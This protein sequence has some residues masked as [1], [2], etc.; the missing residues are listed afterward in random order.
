MTNSGGS[1]HAR[2][3]IAL[4]KILRDCGLSASNGRPL[5]T[6]R[7]TTA[8]IAALK[9]PLIKV[10]VR[11]GATCLDTRWCSQAFVAIASN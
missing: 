1:V 11:A 3:P 8:E 6:Y 5:Y 7:F 10:L 4:D 9:E 2:L